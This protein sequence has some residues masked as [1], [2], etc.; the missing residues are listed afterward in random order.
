MVGGHGTGKSMMIELE[1]SRIAQLHTDADTRAKI[2]IV[3]WEMKAKELLEYYKEFEK[4]IKCDRKVEIC[5]LTKEEICN[6][7][8]VQLSGKNTTTVI[9]EVC[10]RLT[11]MHHFDTYLCIDE[12]EVENPGV[13]VP[14]DLIG[15]VPFVL[16]GKVYP[17]AD[18]NP[19]QVHLITATT[20]DS[21]DLVRIA[22]LTDAEVTEMEASLV[23]LPCGK[24]PT[25]VLW[26]V[27]RCSNSI[28]DF[29]EHF[30]VT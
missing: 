22:N 19:S 17:W 27:F 7:T 8:G 28:Q 11:D 6:Q 13:L 12:I 20:A 10:K 25:E 24:I 1:V 15:K 16:K 3:V 30:Q 23:A 9:N 5:V 2:F 26:R 29:V 21:Q 14:K 4:D 18:L